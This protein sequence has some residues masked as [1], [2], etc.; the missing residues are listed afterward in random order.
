M[1]PILV[2]DF[3]IPLS[4]ELCKIIPSPRYLVSRGSALPGQNGAGVGGLASSSDFRSVYQG[5]VSSLPFLMNDPSD[6][7]FLTLPNSQIL[8]ITLGI[9]SV[10]SV[11]VFH[12]LLPD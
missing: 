6:G 9:F 1:S 4:D 5:E 2:Y 12:S 7:S 3:L 8:F 11:T 10:I